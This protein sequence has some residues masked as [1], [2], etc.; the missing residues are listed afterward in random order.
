M[1]SEDF[2]RKSNLIHGEK[3]DYSKTEYLNYTSKVVIICK[4]HGDFY[5]RANGHLSGK[6]CIKCGGKFKFTKDDFIEKANFIHNN[7]YKYDLVN[8]VNCFSKII[9]TCPIHG[10]FVQFPYK[11]LSKRGCWK[12]CG[13]SKNRRTMKLTLHE[14]IE[15][16]NKIHNSFYDY[17]HVQYLNSNTKIKI[18]CPKHGLFSQLPNNHLSGKGCE[19]CGLKKITKFLTSKSEHEFLDYIGIKPKNKH[20]KIQK[21]IVDGYDPKTNTIYEFLGDYWHGNPSKFDLNK[22]NEVSHKTFG[23]LYH[24]TFNR[25]KILKSYNYNIKYIWELDWKRFSKKI[26]VMPRIL[27]F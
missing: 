3:Y 27:S 7:K 2:I 19:L 6:G 14:F 21:Y 26:D 22:I 20:K 12:C 9:I 5:Q 15:K 8:Y 4:L 25:F 10:N 13:N 23:E 1:T 16:S 11:H 24:K 17:S 18:V